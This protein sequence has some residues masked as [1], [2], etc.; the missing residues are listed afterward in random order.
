MF[1]LIAILSLTSLSYGYPRPRDYGA[2]PH[3][4]MIMVDDWGWANVGYHNGDVDP[5]IA[6]ATQNIDSLVAN[7]IELDQHYTYSV[8]GPTRAALLSGRFSNHVNINNGFCTAYNPD[9][10]TAGGVGIPPAMT[11]IPEK[12]R[13]RGY[14]THAV[15]KWDAGLATSK[16]TPHGRNFDSSLVFFNHMNDMWNMEQ[17]KCGETNITDFWEDETQA[18]YLIDGTYEEE[19]FKDRLQNIIESHDPSEPLFLYYGSR[20]VH[21]PLQVPQSYLDKFSD[22]IYK[23]RQTY[24]AMVNYLDDVIGT[25]K[26]ALETQ[27]MWNNTLLV[28]SSDNGGPLYETAAANNYPLRGGKSSNWQGGIRVNAFVSGGFVPS[29]MRGQVLEEYVHICDWYATF[30]HLAGIDKEDLRAAAADLPEVDSL[31]VWGLLSGENSVSPRT[32]MFFGPQYY[33]GILETSDGIA[34]IKDDYKVLLAQNPW[35]GWTDPISPNETAPVMS[36]MDCSLSSGGCL[37]NIK[38]DPEERDNL[39]SVEVDRLLEM[40]AKAMWYNST[41]YLPDRGH[42]PNP[43]ACEYALNVYDTT[44]GPF[45]NV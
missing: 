44:W 18:N 30:C 37:Y 26:D 14:K 35:A 1:A 25:I 42:S 9:E 43:E 40:A 38:N 3:I 12:L 29:G 45:V 6:R 16:Q 13:R 41:M 34:L 5:D 28:M 23:D 7:G 20:V 19:I 39:A 33:F 2:Q 15:G 27:N 4:V 36:G 24:Y 21:T 8:C 17:G 10:P 31:N 22:I 32:E 11:T